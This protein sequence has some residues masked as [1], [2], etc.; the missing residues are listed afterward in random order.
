MRPIMRYLLKELGREADDVIVEGTISDDLQ[1]KFSN[2]TITGTYTWHIEQ[3]SI[4]TNTKGRLVSTTLQAPS[5][6]SAKRL[7]KRIIEYAKTAPVNREFKG[8]AKGPFKYRPLKEGFDLKIAKLEPVLIKRV[9]DALSH[10]KGR[11]IKRAAGVLEASSFSRIIMSTNKVDG[12]EKGTT[13]YFSFRAFKDKTASGHG[14]GFTRKL[15]KLDTIA[16]IDFAIDIAEQATKP[17]QIPAGKYDVVFAPLA[18]SSLVMHIGNAASAFSVESGSS[19]FVKKIGK[20]VADPTVTLYDDGT[21]PNGYNSAMF[22]DEGRPTQKTAF[23]DKGILK[24]FLHNTSS[25]VRFKA[26]PTGN[27]GII[28]PDNT[29]LV[30]RKGKE[31]KRQ[32]IKKVKKGLYITNVWYTRFQNYHTGDF[33]T[34]PRDGAFLIKD[35][36]ITHPV[37]GIRISENLM[38]LLKNI[39][40]VGNDPQPILGWEAETP[41]MSPHVLVKD[42]NITKPTK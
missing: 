14:V 34:I 8:I 17:K 30:I 26:K 41:C 31:S 40:A 21:L 7:S 18:F 32:L 20:K 13:A 2:S 36:K 5:M 16:I 39:S 15:S 38:S 25:A 10:A 42:V 28:S 33:S 12:T 22:D 1:V 29:N 9:V 19:P 11:G 3:I 6:E 27:A 24:T 23:I 35:G 37:K 4:F